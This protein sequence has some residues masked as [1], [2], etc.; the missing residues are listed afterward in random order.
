MSTPMPMPLARQGKGFA[1]GQ[2]PHSKKG[3]KA[4][5]G[6]E[7]EIEKIEANPLNY[8]DVITILSSILKY[9][10]FL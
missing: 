2:W 4:A 1:L 3:R 7:L 10:L 8:F 6:L 9:I 5:T